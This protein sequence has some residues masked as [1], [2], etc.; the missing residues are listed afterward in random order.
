MAEVVPSELGDLG[1]SKQ[2]RPCLLEAGSDFKDAFP[3]LRLI[4]PTSQYTGGLLIEENVTSLATLRGSTFDG[5]D[6]LLEV[7][8]LP[9]QRQQL[10][11]PKPRVHREQYC[12]C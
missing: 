5:E 11:A 2:A 8:A 12:G 10:A 6:L 1:A 7:N 4:A 9:T 3:T